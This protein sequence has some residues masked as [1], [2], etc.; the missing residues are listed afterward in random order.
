MLPQQDGSKPRG[1]GRISIVNQDGGLVYDTFVHY[2][3]VPHI[4][5]APFRGFGVYKA[6]IQPENGAQLYAD[7]LRVLKTAFDKS[8]VIVGHS[9]QSDIRMPR[10]LDWYPYRLH[11]TQRSKELRSISGQSRQSPD[12][13]G[14]SVV[15]CNSQR[16]RR[17]DSS[18]VW[19]ERG[20]R[21]SWRTRFG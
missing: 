4:V 3:D 13:D 12:Q 16:I 6:D 20:D 5:D 7:V 1:C 15:W 2:G 9:I 17:S 18:K 19:G 10:D 8:G 11:D 14:C 21:S